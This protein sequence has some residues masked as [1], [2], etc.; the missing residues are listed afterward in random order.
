MSVCN[1]ELTAAMQEFFPT[2]PHCK[3]LRHLSE[4]FNKKFGMSHTGTLKSMA[5]A[6]T[7]Q[8]YDKYRSTLGRASKCLEMLAW[9][10]E[11]EP[12]SWCRAHFPVAR[13]GVTISNSI[14]IVF[15]T[16]NKA[17]HLPTVELL[18]WI[19]GYVLANR[20]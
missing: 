9:I 7:V 5:K 15:N 2:I 14:E 19:E 8:K 17:K 6:H 18:L 1:K 13:F 11:A 4:N 16:I 10:D 12:Q 20:F 3:C